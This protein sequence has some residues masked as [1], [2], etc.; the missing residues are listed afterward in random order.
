MNEIKRLHLLQQIVDRQMTAFQAA[1][2]LG[3]SLRQVRRL[4]ARYRQQGAPGIAHGNRGRTPNNQIQDDVRSQILELAENQYQDYNDCHFTEE[5]AEKHGLQVSRSSVRR[6]RRQANLKSPRKRRTP[7]HRSRRERKE[8]AGMLLQADG[9]RHDWLEGRGPW[10]SLIAYIDDATNEVS[11]AV[12]REA[13]DAAGYFLGL[14]QICRQTGIPGAIYADQHTIFQSPAKATLEQELAGEPPRSQFGRLL[15]ELGI[16]LIAARSPQAKG[17]IE[18]L[19]G[20]FQD[21]LVKALREA[22]ASNL[23]EANQVLRSYLPKHNQRFQVK[24]AQEGTAYVPW[25]K[26]YQ[27]KDYFCFKYTRTVTNDNTISFDGHRLQIPPGPHRRSYA[28]AKVEV[29][30]HLDGQLE[31]RY[32]GMSLAT[33]QP[34]DQQPVRVKKFSPLPE[35]ETAKKPGQQKPAPKPEDPK[36]FKPAPDHPWRKPL[37]AKKEEKIE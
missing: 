19:W 15:A 18:R 13:E 31:I 37:V 28:K 29:Q 8:Q 5:L 30:Q 26:E 4:V 24:P 21:R 6:I 27:A 23:V 11:G 16:E 22:G 9:S 2:L 17:R 33:F 32:Q 20:T 35:D 7:R 3:L 34:A 14:Q 10:L 1:E 36:P 12:F 25:P